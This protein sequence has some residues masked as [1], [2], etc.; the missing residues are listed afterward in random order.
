MSGKINK[1][2]KCLKSYSKYSFKFTISLEK[3]MICL[4]FENFDMFPSISYELKIN[5]QELEKIKGFDIF[6]FKDINKLINLIQKSIE[7]DK[8]DIISSKEKII[9]FFN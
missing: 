2:F 3:D 9:L 1:D 8:Y 6:C 7:L 4:F 5:L